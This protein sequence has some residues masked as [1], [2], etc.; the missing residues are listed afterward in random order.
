MTRLA[1]AMRVLVRRCKPPAV[2][3]MVRD[4]PEQWAALES[5]GYRRGWS[6]LFWVYEGSL[7]G[8]KR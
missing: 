4:E 2:E 5:A 3:G 1:L 8:W 6:P 7:E